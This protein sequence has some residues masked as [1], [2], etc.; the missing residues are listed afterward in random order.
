MDR[1]NADLTLV[2]FVY[3]FD[4]DGHHLSLTGRLNDSMLEVRTVNR[5]EET[6]QSLA[7][8]NRKIYP[9]SAIGL[10]PVLHGL[11]VGHHYS[12]W[13]YDGQTRRL[14]E[15]TQHVAGYEESDLYRGAAYKIQTRLHNQN[16]TTWMDALGRPLLEMSLGGVLIAYLEDQATARTYLTHAAL[17]K[18]ETLLN[19]SLV[20]S[21]L[22]VENP[23]ELRRLSVQIDGMPAGLTPPKDSRQTCVRQDDHVRCRIDIDLSARDP[24]LTENDPNPGEPYLLP[25]FAISAGHPEI[26]RLAK[27]ITATARDDLESA[28]F[29]I[30][31][32]QTHIHRK[33]VDGFTAMDVL[34]EGAAEC[35]GHAWLYAAFERSLGVPC[36]VVNGLV[37]CETY[38][39]FLYHSWNET[40]VNGQWLAVDPT[41]GQVPADATHIKL[42]EGSE[43]ADLLPMLD[44]IGKIRIR[45]MDFE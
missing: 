17:N 8:E 40:Y 16:V 7:L 4:L 27:E 38:G 1:V 5:Q 24:I 13:V 11:A 23:R 18:D 35:Q 12:Y 9:A 6:I 2:S 32:M 26:R 20:R 44:I 37:Y 42:L 39:G 19:Y 14:A 34:E 41:F 30:D 45:I 33:A 10:Y 36:R 21:E 25:T 29:L 22:P 31:W 28:R 3:D 43:T 15:V